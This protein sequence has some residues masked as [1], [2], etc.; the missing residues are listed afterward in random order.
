MTI[1][2]P[3]SKQ[4]KVMSMTEFCSWWALSAEMSGAKL[5]TGKW[6]R[7]KGTRFVWNSFRSTFR[8]PSKQR[9]AVIDKT[10]YAIKQLRFVKLG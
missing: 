5:A 3:A 2:L 7:G 9:E 1:W 10:T 8:E 6:I 4:E